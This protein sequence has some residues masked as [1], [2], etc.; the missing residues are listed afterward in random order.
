M[1]T[2]DLNWPQ[3]A[4]RVAWTAELAAALEALG[5][6]V[7]PEGR[8][9]RFAGPGC[10]VSVTLEEGRAQGF[11]CWRGKP[12]TS[13]MMATGDDVLRFLAPIPAHG[14]SGAAL[15]Q[16]LAWWGWQ[17]PARKAPPPPP[18]PPMVI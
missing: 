12:A 16:W 13:A 3:L 15:R 7:P 5:L 4:R 8:P 1:T 17:P 10:L 9:R 6:E 14:A 11:L 2:P 18:P